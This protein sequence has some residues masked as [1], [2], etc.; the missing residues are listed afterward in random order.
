MLDSVM[1]A[2]SAAGR[3]AGRRGLRSALTTMV[4]SITV[5]AGVFAPGHLGELT[6]QVPFELVD[7][8]LVQ[9]R[10][11][12]RRL[13]AL[14]SRVGVYFVLALCLFPGV[15]YPKVW[16]KLIAALDTG[17]V[18]S[19][20]GK[21]LRDLR[22]R[23]GVAPLE[24]LFDVLAG[25]VARPT[26]PG[27]RFG[28]YRT[29]SFDGC[30]SI[31][32]PDTGP[33]RCWLGKMRAALGVTGYPAV[34]LMTLVETGTRALL[35]AVFG[36]PAT[37]ETDYARRLLAR[38]GPD[39]LV[40]ADRGFDGAAFL[41]E[42]AGTGAQFLVRV[43]STRRPPV[44]ARLDDGS[45]LSRIGALTVRIITADIT[46]TCADGTRYTASY[47]L[48]TTLVDPRRYPAAALIALYHERWEHE[49]AY[50]AL[51]HTLLQGRVL[52]SADPKGL[53]QEMW[54]LLTVYQALRIA[55]VDAVE[56][57]PG[58]DPD[59]ASFATALETAKDLLVRAENVITADDDLVGR[60]GRAIL[61]DL[62][63]PRR[64]RTKRPQG[65]IPA[66]A[67]QQERPLPAR[68]QHTDH[69]RGRHHQRPRTER[70]DTPIEMLDH[71]PRALTTRHWR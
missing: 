47:R 69:R 18:P 65:Q 37:G 67:L 8:V 66:L 38:L 25:P 53:R 23:V 40:L 43:C 57:V 71:G 46:V 7:S 51:R 13:R 9:T 45:F 41:T 27:V 68:T 11:T 24:A 21:A 28:R 39:M 15:G 10:A 44:L 52:R 17:S 48:V 42:L 4:R 5:A 6:R 31:K 1:P 61:D 70:H 54:A 60:I 30:T 16:D 3:G 59:R 35:G 64:P 12:E 19:V 36:P 62:H 50:L 55:M 20:S 32:V 26:T 33:N 29:V 49:I 63:P 2:R 56:T 14:P 34:E 22:R 58:T